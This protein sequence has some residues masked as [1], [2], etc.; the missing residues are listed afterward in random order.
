MPANLAAKPNPS[1]S[2]PSYYV[3]QQHLYGYVV[4]QRGYRLDGPGSMSDSSFGEM[5]LIS[6]AININGRQPLTE[7]SYASS[8]TVAVNSNDFELA[9]GAHSPAGAE[10]PSQHAYDTPQDVYMGVGG[11]AGLSLGELSYTPSPYMDPSPSWPQSSSSFLSFFEASQQPS[12]ST[13][14][15]GYDAKPAAYSASCDIERRSHDYQW[16]DEQSTTG[17][18]SGRNH[19]ASVQAMQETGFWQS[20]AEANI[21]AGPSHSPSKSL[22]ATN[23]W[24]PHYTDSFGASGS[25][26]SLPGL[27]FSPPPEMQSAAY[28]VDPSSQSLIPETLSPYSPSLFDA[29]SPSKQRVSVAPIGRC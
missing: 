29:S 12:T 17:I 2:P 23:S 1:Q 27:E 22:G 20:S 13:Y 18:H 10:F 19:G 26:R 3:S 6:N 24:I 5:S 11:Q 16:G 28:Q 8:S 9:V 21:L 4:P 25:S 15:S 7:T 14:A